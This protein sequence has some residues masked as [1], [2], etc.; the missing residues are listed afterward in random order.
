M[1]RTGTFTS[2]QMAGGKARLA[3]LFRGRPRKV[4]DWISNTFTA[5]KCGFVF[6]PY[7]LWTVQAA[8]GRASPLFRARPGAAPDTQAAPLIG[9]DRHR[10]P[11]PGRVGSPAEP[12]CGHQGMDAASLASE[13]GRA[14]D[15]RK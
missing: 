13:A 7:S 9:H 2:R 8:S 3:P 11:S 6:T 1:R 10:P 14:Y 12:S 5:K 15:R 4:S